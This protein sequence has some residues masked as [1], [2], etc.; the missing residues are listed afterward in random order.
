M[1]VTGDAT[2]EVVCYDDTFQPNCSD[3]VNKVIEI[4]SAGYGR[5][6]F[7]K[8]IKPKKEL[9]QT[10]SDYPPYKCRDDATVIVRGQCSGKSVCGIDIKDQIFKSVMK[11]CDDQYKNYLN[12]SYV[13]VTGLCLVCRSE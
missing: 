9:N 11:S 6:H 5:M 10:T 2:V 13:C 1:M 12:V 4:I 7:G 3:D 8:C